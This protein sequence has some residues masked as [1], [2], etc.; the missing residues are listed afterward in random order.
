MT[1]LNDAFKWELTSEDIGYE[2][3]SKSLSVPTPLCQEPQPF[4]VSTHENISF[5]PATPRVCPSPDYLHAV[6]H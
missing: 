2:S 4:H 6:H 1:T 5:G 3:G